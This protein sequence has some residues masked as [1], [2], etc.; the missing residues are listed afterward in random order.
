M[1]KLMPVVTMAVAALAF[2]TPAFSAE[3]HEDKIPL[4]AEKVPPGAEGE[5]LKEE[6]DEFPLTFGFDNDLFTAYVWRNSV[7]GDELVWQ[8][9]VWVDFN[10]LDWFT[11]GG[12]VWQNW[13]L[14]ANPSKLGRPR[15]MNETDFNVHLTR[16]IWSTEDEEYDLG[17]EVGSDIYTYRQW[18]DTS[19]AYEF[20]LKLTFD[21]PFVSVYGQYSQ[22]FDPVA[23]PYFEGGLKKEI[24]FSDIVSSESEFLDRWTFAADWNMS[25]ASGKYFTS[26]LYGTLP[27]EYDP[28]TDEYDK[29]G[30]SNG[31]GG[32][33]IKGTIAY[34]V[35]E[36][37][38]LGLVCAYTAL[39]SGEACDAMDFAECGNMYKRLVWGGLQAKVEF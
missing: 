37:F 10:V 14:T 8:P 16:S 12:F 36:H 17:V 23:A 11:L 13:D 31:I 39:L 32:T 30:M 4:P 6:T 7:Q 38:S 29:R 5:V 26:Y 18:E 28:E 19:N 3:K 24:K 2:S 21:N 27:G 33:T 35:C 20:Y 15:A 1:S 34:Q 25:F 9:C 22:A